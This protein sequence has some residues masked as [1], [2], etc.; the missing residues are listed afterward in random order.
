MS[1]YHKYP[2]NWLS[3]IRPRILERDNRTCQHCGN[4]ENDICYDSITKKTIRIILHI[5]HLDRDA[6]NWDVT[7]DRLLALCGSC[8]LRYDA[9]HRTHGERKKTKQNYFI[10]DE[11]YVFLA[12]RPLIHIHGLEEICKVPKGTIRLGNKI[13]NQYRQR[14]IQELNLYGYS[15]KHLS[16][17]VVSQLN[18]VMQ[19]IEDNKTMWGADEI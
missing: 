9:P 5:A 13:P 19:L 16:T 17:E 1:F 3:E 11:I 14:I 15:S 8:H 18:N 12:K 6:E 7:D 4:K 2:P 10:M